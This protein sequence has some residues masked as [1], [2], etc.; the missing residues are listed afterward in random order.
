MARTFAQRFNH[1]YGNV[2]PEPAAFN[3]GETL[4]KIPGLDGT[5]KMSKSENHMATLFL[6]D[7]DDSIRKKIMKAKTDNGPSA[8]NSEKPD[9]IENIFLLMKLVSS[10]EVISKYEDD[11][12]NCVIRYGDLKKQLGEDMVQFITPIRQ[13]ALDIMHDEKYLQQ[14][15]E[16]GAQKARASAAST[17]QVV[18]SAMGLSYF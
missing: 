1:R 17:M 4:I 12:N 3:F 6:A 5:G 14:V 11:F 18:R 7:D 16:S 13:K 10:P 2:F 8:M 15:M 9:Y